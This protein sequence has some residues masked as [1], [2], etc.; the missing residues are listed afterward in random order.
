[1]KRGFDPIFFLVAAGL[2]GAI[3]AGAQEQTR[4]IGVYPGN[5]KE[6]AGP[7]L[8]IDA[9]TYRNL[10]LRRPVYQSSAYDYNLT[11]QL[12]ADGIKETRLPRWVAT[13]SSLGG[14]FAKN[15]REW[16]LD[17][18]SVTGPDLAGPG[19]WVSVELGGGEAPPVIDRI[20]LDARSERGGWTAVVSGSADGQTWTELGR[21]VGVNKAGKRYEP[22]W[23][24][25]P[26]MSP[27]RTRHY[28]VAIEGADAG[29]WHVANLRFLSVGQRVRVGGPFDFTSAWKSA[30][31]GEEWVSVDLGATCAFDRVTLTWIR[32]AAEGA[33][34]V[35]EN[36]E[37]WTTVQALGPEDDIRLTAPARGR[38]VRV[39]MT[40]PESPGGYILGELEVFGRGGPVPVPK[41][42]PP[43]RADGR[44]DLT[45]GGWRLQRD[46]LV[47]ADGKALSIPGF[48]DGDWPVATVPAT[49]LVSYLNAGALPDPNFG[50]NITAISDSFFYADFWYRN[51]F[52]VPPS[53]PGRRTWLHFDGVNWKAE[54]YLNGEKLGRIEGGFMRGRFDVTDRLR[55]GAKN[56]LAVRVEKIANPGHVKEKTFRDPDKNGGI[57]GADNPTYHASIG[58]D[59]I[60]TIRGRNTG[61]W[62][63]VYLTATGD[64][65]VED[66]LV[67]TKL[68]GS[69]SR[70]RRGRRR[71]RAEKPRLVDGQG[72]PARPVRR[73][74]L[75]SLGDAGGGGGEN[76]AD[77][78]A[79][80]A[81]PADREPEALVAGGLRRAEP[82]IPWSS[83]SRRGR[84]NPKSRTRCRSR[85]GSGKSATARRAAPC[86]CGSTAGAS[87]RAAATGA[88]ANR[89]SATAAASTTPR[90]DITGT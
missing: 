87:W 62:N 43:V 66:P 67:T 18:N 76:G 50:D 78:S 85:R 90:C 8:R 74:R 89:C 54:V 63:D 24:A 29:P 80:P 65:T 21:A 15:E 14:A 69:G 19:A 17:D 68:S 41:A 45:G 32:R 77:R 79:N 61:L 13:S 84:R 10:A 49:T 35:S 52:M 7:S 88:S 60:P 38:Y 82:L 30:G 9:T 4:G 53:R 23:T 25:I 56:A 72:D 2:A 5:P 11:A 86:G 28:R 39:L 44:L 48:A 42:A 31:A 20:D 58:W 3:A 46:S 27:T 83:G 64:V 75:R 26:F 16:L 6:Y 81:R 1:M 47:Q 36:A 71:G 73:R 51:E 22:S 34:Q 57:L 12:V 40:K 37:D 70:R 33:I 55:A 59:W